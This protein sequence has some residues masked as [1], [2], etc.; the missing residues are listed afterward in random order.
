M[1]ETK[2][3][4][5]TEYP[6]G[7]ILIDPTVEQMSDA[8]AKGL[9]PEAGRALLHLAQAGKM[10]HNELEMI[11]RAWTQLG[12]EVDLPVKDCI[13]YDPTMLPS[14]VG[15]VDSISFREKI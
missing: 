11:D 10:N 15:V 4:R 6:T 2:L 8:R 3:P 7:E 9:N 12:D 13:E 5:S 14:Q 1:M